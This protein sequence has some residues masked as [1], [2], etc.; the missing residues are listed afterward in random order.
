MEMFL[1][2]AL[3][4]TLIFIFSQSAI[5]FFLRKENKQ[6]ELE[7]EKLSPPF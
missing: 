1:A 3:L 5:I 4:A 7:L 2:V 6:L